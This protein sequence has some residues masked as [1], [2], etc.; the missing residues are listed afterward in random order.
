MYSPQGPLALDPHYPAQHPRRFSNTAPLSPLH[1]S[2]TRTGTYLRRSLEELGSRAKRTGDALRMCMGKRRRGTA[3]R[4]EDIGLEHTSARTF[5]GSS[6][7]VN[8][9]GE[10][11]WSMTR[12]QREGVV[13]RG[14]DP[15]EAP[16]VP[17]DM[18]P[19]RASGATISASGPP[20][21]A[22]IRLQY[23]SGSSNQ[24]VLWLAVYHFDSILDTLAHGSSTTH[25]KLL[26][27]HMCFSPQTSVFWPAQCFGRISQTL[28]SSRP[29]NVGVLSSLCY[30]PVHGLRAA[31]VPAQHAAKEGQSDT[32]P[33]ADRTLGCFRRLK[34]YDEVLGYLYFYELAY[35]TCNY[36]RGCSS[37][38]SAR[39]PPTCS[40]REAVVLRFQSVLRLEQQ[41]REHVSA[42]GG[43]G[44]RVVGRGRYSG[45]GVMGKR[46][47]KGRGWAEGLNA[48]LNTIEKMRH[49]QDRGKPF[50]PTSSSSSPSASSSVPRPCESGA[51]RIRRLLSLAPVA[52]QPRPA[53]SSPSS[54]Y[55]SEVPPS[56]N[57]APTQS[58]PPLPFNDFSP[59]A[60]DTASYPTPLLQR[61]FAA[62]NDVSN[63][64]SNNTIFEN[65]HEDAPAPLPA[66]HQPSTHDACKK[67]AKPNRRKGESPE[68]VHRRQGKYMAEHREDAPDVRR[69]YER[70]RNRFHTGTA[71]M[72]RYAQAGT[73]VSPAGAGL[74]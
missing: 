24:R 74:A 68:E 36:R 60:H 6:G 71:P 59:R 3:G 54:A 30:I 13:Q 12:I 44:W 65:A 4:E 1:L 41:R 17:S 63:G 57:L 32:H 34:G 53:I 62:L 43:G 33:D 64:F 50:R 10:A 28:A 45:V 70:P 72:G 58:T 52:L 49:H 69:G 16:C 23:D 20:D 5:G 26:G 39:T 37:E 42:Q 2:T 66:I 48:H 7:L 31:P 11:E 61:A 27:L 14:Q 40:Q 25:Y 19:Q 15:V 67:P 29:F 51:R 46:R 9:R 47:G 38:I 21:R 56:V 35:L 8:R 55:E 18:A 73:T 22:S